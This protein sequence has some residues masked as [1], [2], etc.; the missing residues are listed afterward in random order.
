MTGGVSEAAAGA[1][2]DTVPALEQE[3]TD[4]RGGGGMK[5]AY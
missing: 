5:I 4:L 2:A 1:G 3:R